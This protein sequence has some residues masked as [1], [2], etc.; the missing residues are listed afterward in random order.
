MGKFKFINIILNFSAYI[1]LIVWKIT[2]LENQNSFCHFLPCFSI[3]PDSE[4]GG[5]EMNY[6]CK[7]TV[8]KSVSLNDLTTYGLAALP[9]VR[10]DHMFSCPN[11]QNINV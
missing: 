9:E 6:I 1:S 11:F 8:Q 2:E 5:F 4:D 7:K 3:Y 10:N